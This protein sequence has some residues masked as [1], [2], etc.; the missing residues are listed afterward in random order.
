MEVN[1][2]FGMKP[3][4]QTHNISL[5]TSEYEEEVA[6]VEEKQ[7]PVKE[8]EKETLEQLKKEVD[9]REIRYAYICAAEIVDNN[10]INY[11]IKSNMPLKIGPVEIKEIEDIA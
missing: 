3:Q 1:K 10:T 8:T 5:S 11:L 7:Q 4:K 6:Q 9:I 2:M